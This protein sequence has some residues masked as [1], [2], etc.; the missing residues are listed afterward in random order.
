MRSYLFVAGNCINQVSALRA[1]LSQRLKN[2]FFGRPQFYHLHKFLLMR[3]KITNFH[4][5]SVSNGYDFASAFDEDVFFFILLYFQHQ[6][7]SPSRRPVVLY[8]G[9]KVR[10]FRIQNGLLRRENWNGEQKKMRTEYRKKNFFCFKS[11]NRAAHQIRIGA[12]KSKGNLTFLS[13]PLWTR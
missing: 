3:D 5:Y 11:G 6:I 13:T 12:L 1:S 10:W 2:H 9:D 7:W 8:F 4:R